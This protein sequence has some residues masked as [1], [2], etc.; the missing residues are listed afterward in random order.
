MKQWWKWYGAVVILLV[1]WIISVLIFHSST[2]DVVSGDAGVGAHFWAGLFGNL[3]AEWAH[4]LFSTAILVGFGRA[5]FK[6][7]YEDVDRIERKLDE[8][9][10]HVR[11]EGMPAVAGDVN[12]GALRP[13]TRRGGRPGGE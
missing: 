7:G 4:L 8:L 1:L 6:R 12:L 11:P 13:P 10:Q 3:Q 2:E 9:L 5:C